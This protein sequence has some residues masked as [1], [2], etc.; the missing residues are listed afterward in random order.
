MRYLKKQ[1]NMAQSK[2]TNPS[3]IEVNELPDKKYSKKSS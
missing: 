3:E 1:R 2:E